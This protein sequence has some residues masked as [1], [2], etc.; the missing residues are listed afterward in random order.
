MAPLPIS[1]SILSSSSTDA[2]DPSTI[3]DLH[4]SSLELD[5]RSFS[6]ADEANTSPL[7]PRSAYALL[8]ARDAATDSNGANY[9]PGSGTIP[10]TAINNNG[11]FAVFGLVSASL[12]CACI[13]FFFWAKNGGFVWRKGDWDEYK[14]TVLRRKGPN[15]T[16]LSGATKT[17]ELGGGSIVGGGSS[18][19]SFESGAPTY[20]DDVGSV[21]VVANG[22]KEKAKDKRKTKTA[23]GRKAKDAD[24]RAYRHEKPAKV[25]GLNR[26]PDGSYHDYS[27]AGGAPSEASAFP[28]GAPHSSKSNPHHH[29]NNR[30][31]LREPSYTLGSEASFSVLSSADSRRPLRHPHHPSRQR[32]PTKPHP[33]RRPRPSDAD[34]YTAPIDFESRYAP[35]ASDAETGVTA[36]DDQ[37]AGTKSYFHPIPGL[38]SASRAAAAGAVEKRKD[39]DHANAKKAPGGFRRGNQPA[40][41]MRRRDSLSDS[42][43][44]T[45]SGWGSSVV[46]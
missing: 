8:H 2:F 36:A 14:S 5:R 44:E 40:G 35:S 12:V 26:Q 22:T 1:A 4:L 46:S 10:P 33:S 34:R 42:E 13:W 16:T 25:G 37:S 3:S 24:V 23:R 27:S 38:G 30:T 28:Y 43:G 39:S 9:R 17:T 19:A 31:P 29:H 41:P 20:T 11:I 32:E 21:S 15:G 6:P 45:R 7:S 18:D